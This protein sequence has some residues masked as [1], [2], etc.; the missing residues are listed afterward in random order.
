MFHFLKSLLGNTKKKEKK[1]YRGKN[2]FTIFCPD[3]VTVVIL[4]NFCGQ[5]ETLLALPV[6][7]ENETA[8]QLWLM[9]F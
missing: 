7:S 8:R 1:I 2:H 5:S 4:V 9:F 3:S 6:Q